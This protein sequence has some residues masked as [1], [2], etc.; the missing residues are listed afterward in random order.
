MALRKDGDPAGGTARRRALGFGIVALVVATGTAFVVYATL[1]AYERDRVHLTSEAEG[2]RVVVALKDLPAG[3]ILKAED[4]G[5]GSAVGVPQDEVFRVIDEVAGEALADRVLVGEAIRPQRLVVMGAANLRVDQVIDPSSRAVALRLDADASM[6]G[7]LRPGHFVDVFVTIPRAM[8][9]GGTDWVTE[10]VVQGVRVVA[11]DG[12]VAP[13]PARVGLQTVAGDL[14]STR[15]VTLEVEPTEAKGLVHATQ[16]GRVHLAL[17]SPVNFDVAEYGGP[18]ITRDMVGVPLSV[19]EE[20]LARKRAIDDPSAQ[21]QRTMA[22]IQIMRGSARST[23][24][25]DREEAP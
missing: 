6:G 21:A 19:Q 3:H 13:G 4:L 14:L 23:A 11:I 25:M 8:P 16:R 12:D 1:S 18:L 9:D 5:Y 24:P 2:A 22:V 10:A 7:L 17:R 20:R 15:L